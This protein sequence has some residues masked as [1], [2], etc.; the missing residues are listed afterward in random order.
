MSQQR[1]AK[2]LWNSP[3]GSDETW[4]VILGIALTAAFVA[5]L[6][7]AGA[8]SRDGRSGHHWVCTKSDRFL[9]DK[10]TGIEEECVEGYWAPD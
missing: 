8:E 3:Q 9:V 2:S 6:W 4:Q 1:P 7:L 10:F 5:I